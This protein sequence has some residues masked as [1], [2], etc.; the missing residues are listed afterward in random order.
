[1]F[2]VLEGRRRRRVISPTTLA[3]SVAAHVLLLGGAVY[4]AATE[5]APREVAGPVYELPPLPQAPPPI[6]RAEDPAPPPPPAQPRDEPAEAPVQ[7]T[8]VVFEAP[9]EVPTRLPPPE[10]SGPPVDPRHSPGFGD[11]A[12]VY[13]P[14]TGDDRPATGDPGG[15]PAPEFIPGPEDVEELP[16]LDREGLS[17]ALERYYPAALRNAGVPGLVVVEVIVNEDGRVRP[18][19]ARIVEASHAAFEGATLRAVERF[20]F[21]PG[22]MAGIAVPVRVTIPIRWTPVH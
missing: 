2:Q 3:A 4:A 9:H 12:D 20:R 17:R 19:S 1:M 5:P 21:R 15:G 11:D 10:L 18:G 16:A 13:G 8:N 6:E 7:G 14:P 22:R